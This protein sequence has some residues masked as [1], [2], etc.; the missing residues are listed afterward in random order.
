[1]YLNALKQKRISTLCQFKFI[2]WNFL[3]FSFQKSYLNSSQTRFHIFFLS[4]FIYFVFFIHS[5]WSSHTNYFFEIRFRE[6][7][8]HIQIYRHANNVVAHTY[9]HTYKLHKY[10]HIRWLAFRLS[11]ILIT[12]SNRKSIFISFE[13]TNLYFSL[14]LYLCLAF[15]C[16]FLLLLY[17]CWNYI[18]MD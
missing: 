1:M 3:H 7:I 2:K 8:K 9:I 13:S 12:F 18:N 16:I 4:F 14:S 6:K 11:S 10:T 5:M 15:V 17:F